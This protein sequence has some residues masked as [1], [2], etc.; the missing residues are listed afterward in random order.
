MQAFIIL[1]IGPHDAKTEFYLISM[2]LDG[3]NWK[4]LFNRDIFFHDL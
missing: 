4:M 1:I 2:A 3:T